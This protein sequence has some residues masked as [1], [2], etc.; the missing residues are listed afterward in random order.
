MSSKQADASPV[1]VAITSAT[2]SSGHDEV[3]KVNFLNLQCHISNEHEKVSITPLSDA[4]LR[5]R[6][7][8]VLLSCH[9]AL[10]QTKHLTDNYVSLRTGFNVKTQ[11]S[12]NNKLHKT[13]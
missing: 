8:A 10:H 13:S 11:I 7:R 5:E 4:V 3:D 9:S 1:P 2:S 12:S 6:L